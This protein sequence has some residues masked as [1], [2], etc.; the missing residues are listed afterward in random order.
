MI[1]K[2]KEVRD[3]LKRCESSDLEESVYSYPENERDGRDDYQVLADEASWMIHCYEAD[4]HMFADSLEEAR[5]IMRKTHRGKV[6]PVDIRTLKP[7]YDEWDINRARE[8][9]NEVNRVKRLIK[10]LEA[11]GYFGSY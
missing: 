10:K 7:M 6:I 11:R 3:L 9:I 4:D 1:I 8:L 5:E 2:T